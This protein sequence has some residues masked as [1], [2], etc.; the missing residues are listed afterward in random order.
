MTN[1]SKHFCVVLITELNLDAGE[2]HEYL[3][4]NKS[5]GATSL[6]INDK[7]INTICF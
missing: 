3:P 5:P 7:P 2:H 1:I 6:H 4:S